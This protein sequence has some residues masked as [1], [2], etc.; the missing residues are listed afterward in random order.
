[1]FEAVAEAALVQPTFV[2]EHPVEISPL[3]KPHRAKRGVTE[4]FELFVACEFGLLG[5]GG[6]LVFERGEDR[7][8]ARYG[9]FFDCSNQQRAQ[10]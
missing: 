2:L 8:H 6:G 5:Y 10:S 1:M 7:T 9:V 3:A 4:R